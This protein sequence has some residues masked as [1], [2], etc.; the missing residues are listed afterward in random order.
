MAPMAVSIVDSHFLKPENSPLLTLLEKHNI[1]PHVFM[2]ID[3]LLD[4]L[5]LNYTHNIVLREVDYQKATT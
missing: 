3:C 1:Q 5:A 2:N 4:S